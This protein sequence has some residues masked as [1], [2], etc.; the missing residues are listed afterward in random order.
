LPLEG[1]RRV[2]EQ[3]K[4]MGSFE[5]YHTSFSYSDNETGEEKFVG[6][7][8]QGG[9]DLISTD[10]LA[11]GTVYTPPSA[12]TAPSASTASRSRVSGTGKLKLAGGVAGAMKE[13]VQRAF[14]YLQ[15][16]KTELGIAA[17][18]TPLGHPRRGHRPPRATASRPSSAWPS[19]SP[20]TRRCA[21]RPSAP[22]CS[23]SAT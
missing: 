21:R 13:S 7:P 9:R 5:Y 12:A 20:P 2:K 18:S 23:S 11:P 16:K 8:E 10:P 1:R 17:T 14:S 22:R 4:K 19:S 3:L 6:V 15:A